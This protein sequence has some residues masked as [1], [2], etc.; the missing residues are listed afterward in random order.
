MDALEVSQTAQDVTIVVLRGEHDIR[1]APQLRSRLRATVETGNPV[2]VDLSEVTF[3]DST[4]LH[5]LLEADELAREKG[6]ALT[7]QVGTSPMVRRILEVSGVT[8]RVVCAGD[9]DAAL[10]LARN[11]RA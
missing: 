10:R 7:M 8:D 6:H 3:F 11:G 9:R 4:V 2:V 1:S 5:A